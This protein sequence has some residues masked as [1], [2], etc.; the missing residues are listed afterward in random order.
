MTIRK[1][2]IFSLLA[3]LTISCKANNKTDS[4]WN[5]EF[6]CAQDII[7]T[8]HTIKKSTSKKDKEQ[9]ALNACNFIW[10]SGEYMFKCRGKNEDIALLPE[11]AQELELDNE[12]V[13]KYMQEHKMARLADH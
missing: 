5:R 1:T 13:A 2:L 12:I 4:L 9:Q 11:Y 10:Q 8:Y 6:A 7:D 3:L